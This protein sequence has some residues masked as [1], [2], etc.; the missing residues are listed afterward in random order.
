MWEYEGH[1]RVY[2]TMSGCAQ[3]THAGGPRLTSQGAHGACQQDRS[4]CANALPKIL[5]AGA[6]RSPVPIGGGAGQTYGKDSYDAR[7]PLVQVH[8]SY[9]AACDAVG[10][11]NQDVHSLRFF[12]RILV[13][14]DSVGV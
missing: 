8:T 5:V 4:C 12:E 11:F 14:S 9:D 3:I 1:D 6:P 7:H 2:I 10:G 13:D